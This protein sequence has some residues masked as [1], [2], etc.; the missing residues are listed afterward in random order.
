MMA[1]QSDMSSNLSVY[2][3][4]CT[5]VERRFRSIPIL[6]VDLIYYLPL[7]VLSGEDD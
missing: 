5:S 7:S 2:D 1:L 4:N 6:C 3:M